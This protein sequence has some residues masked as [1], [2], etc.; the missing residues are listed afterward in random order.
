MGTEPTERK[1]LVVEDNKRIRNI[2]VQYLRSEWNISAY[3]SINKVKEKDYRESN[4]ALL[5]LILTEEDGKLVWDLIKKRAKD[6]AIALTE[7]EGLSS[8][9]ALGKLKK[10]GCITIMTSRIVDSRIIMCALE[11]GAFWYLPKPEVITTEEIIEAQNP[12]EIVRAKEEKILLT[13]ELLREW[14]VLLERAA[15]TRIAH[16]CMKYLPLNFIE[17]IKKNSSFFKPDTVSTNSVA[18]LLDVRNS[19]YLWQKVR[20]GPIGITNVLNEIFRIAIEVIKN[21]GGYIDS[22]AGDALLAFFNIHQSNVD[23]AKV[24]EAAQ[25][26]K[27]TFIKEEEKKYPKI[28][29]KI[30]IIKLSPNTS[31]VAHLGSEARKQMTVMSEQLYE[32]SRVMSELPRREPFDIKPDWIKSLQDRQNPIILIGEIINDVP[33]SYRIN[34]IG[35]VK[36]RGIYDLDTAEIRKVDVAELLT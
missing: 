9:K 32:L 5:D 11:K 34:K 36:I 27:N 3:P 12:Q 13:A 1:L 17:E 2:I 4:V 28:G 23:P 21:N 18:L 6:K 22:F 10:R 33:S 15:D 35:Q 8:F 31:I 14:G 19:A 7:L 24:L 26:I 29:L 30:G 20:G 25:N 16:Y